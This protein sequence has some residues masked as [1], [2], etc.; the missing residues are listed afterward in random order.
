MRFLIKP[1]NQESEKEFFRNLFMDGESRG[2]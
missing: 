1:G 2:A